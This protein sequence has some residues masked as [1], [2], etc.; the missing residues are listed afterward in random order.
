MALRN[1]RRPEERTNGRTNETNGR[2]ILFR[3]AGSAVEGV[4]I[5]SGTNESSVYPIAA[6]S[7]A[8]DSAGANAFVQYVLS[9]AGRT[10]LL[11]AGFGPP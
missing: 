3:A 6:L 11:A 1:E 9:P 5:L 4:P 7:D 2:T 10:V 8:P